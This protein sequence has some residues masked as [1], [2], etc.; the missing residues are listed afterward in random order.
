MACF[1]FAVEDMQSSYYAWNFYGDDSSNGYHPEMDYIY[2]APMGDYYNVD[3]SVYAREFENSIVVAN[4]ATSSSTFEI[5]GESYTLEGRTSLIIEKT[6]ENTPPIVSNIPDQTIN[7]GESFT[8]INLDEYVTDLEDSDEH[9]IWS[10]SGN[11]NLIVNIDSNHVVRIGLPNSNWNGQEDITFTA[12]DTGGLTD[13]DSSTFT[14]KTGNNKRKAFST[15]T[16]NHVYFQ[17]RKLF[18][19]N[20]LAKLKIDVLAFGPT[21]F[22][23]DIDES[24]VG[25]IGIVEFYIEDEYKYSTTGNKCEWTWDEQVIGKYLV[26]TI[27]Y[28][29]DGT[30]VI[31]DEINVFI[32]NLRSEK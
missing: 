30:Q 4:I 2:G 12:E 29:T 14:I 3:D 20:F 21:T 26:K 13:Q 11:T 1:L 7:K 27:A 17:G 15:P 22:E 32:L 24:E 5:N 10:Y 19:S 6:S 8:T 25:E 18:K 28:D 16:T 23:I 31:R 9:I